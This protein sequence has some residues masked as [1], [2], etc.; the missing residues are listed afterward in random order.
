VTDERPTGHPDSLPAPRDEPRSA[1]LLVEVTAES[2]DDVAAALFELGATGIEERDETT[3]ER[4]PGPGMVTLVGTFADRARADGAAA[5][6]DPALAPR[7]DELAGDAWRDAW[8]EYFVPF[9]LTDRIVIRPPWEPYEPKDDREIVLELEPGRAFGTGL[10]ATTALIARALA[11]RESRLR[12]ARVLDVGTGSG[13]LALV[14]ASLGAA[15]V[16]AVDID[17][18]A[19]EVAK[20]NI[21]RNA[22]QGRVE[23]DTSS[24][25]SL[26]PA[27]DVV[28]VNI[29]A[30]TIVS[31]AAV[32]AQRVENGGFLLLSGI[33]QHQVDQVGKAFG[34]FVIEDRPEDGEWVAVVLRR[35]APE[36]P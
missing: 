24:V 25:D 31:L 1:L 15:S 28:T 27:Y 26:S 23:A 10:H 13:I 29:E 2:S 19:I 34:G 8:K 9:R 21:G 7:V 33:L 18:D 32:L 6:L 16:R 14:A 20:A 11:A 12:G 5:A 35:V 4:G 22:M 17:A 3:L 30:A 36:A